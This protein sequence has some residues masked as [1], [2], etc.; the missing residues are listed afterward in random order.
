[1]LAVEI[2]PHS[3]H[4]ARLSEQ[5]DQDEREASHVCGQPRL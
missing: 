4:T 2:G 1:M 5:H 3:F